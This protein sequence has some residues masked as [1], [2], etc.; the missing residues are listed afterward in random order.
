MTLDV[1]KLSDSGVHVKTRVFVRGELGTRASSRPRRRPDH[2]MDTAAG[3]VHS[4]VSGISS[5]FG[6]EPAPEPLP[7]YLEWWVFFGFYVLR[8]VWHVPLAPKVQA[9]RTRPAPRTLSLHHTCAP[10]VRP[11]QWMLPVLFAFFVVSGLYEHSPTPVIFVEALAPAIVP[12]AVAVNVHFWARAVMLKRRTHA[13]ACLALY[14]AHVYAGTTEALVDALP[15]APA[16]HVEPLRLLA[17]HVGMLVVLGLTASLPKA[18]V[19]VRANPKVNPNPNLNPSPNPIPNLNPNQSLPEADG[20][21]P[22]AA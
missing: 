18:K 14:V 22:K 13:L 17:N 2:K 9:P 7:W 21:K 4:F 19:S 5:L 20:A 11:S 10:L 12:A 6:A 3:Y 8:I 16:A 1:R 15:S